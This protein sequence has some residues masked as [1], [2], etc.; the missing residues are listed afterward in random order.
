[1]TAASDLARPRRPREERARRAALDA[2]L[3]LIVERGIAGVTTAAVAERA[4]TSKATMYR[5]W[6]SKDALVADA[7]GTL[8]DREIALPDTGSLAEDLRAL[9]RGAVAL[10]STP[11]AAALVPELVAAM[12]RTPRLAAAVRDEFLGRRRAALAEV[13]ERA[14]ARGE[15]HGRV[16]RELCLDVLGGPI[17]YRLLIT[18]APLDERL[19]D[20][21]ADLILRAIT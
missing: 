15:L 5:H 7:I 12:A 4:R 9:L 16:D 8:V 10:Y 20:D 6:P 11:D 2:T 1:M 14:E 21:L 18:G 19:A 17:F 3:A 13:L